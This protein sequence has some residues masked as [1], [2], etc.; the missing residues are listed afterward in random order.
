MV[1][2]GA[3]EGAEGL[4]PPGPLRPCPDCYALRTQDARVLL[5][6][7]SLRVAASQ[8]IV[9]TGASG[10]NTFILKKTLH[11]LFNQGPGQDLR[12][13]AGT[14]PLGQVLMK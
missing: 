9:V 4:P 7:L 5:L 8:D 12:T 3:G 1:L 13:V 10:Y 11:Y 14:S 6:A 2:G